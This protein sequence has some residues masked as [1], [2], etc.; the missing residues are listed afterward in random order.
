M[1]EVSTD[2]PS[3]VAPLVMHASGK[4]RGVH[5][6]PW[7]VTG[8][9]CQHPAFVLWFKQPP[10]RHWPSPEV[11]KTRAED[12]ELHSMSPGL[13][14]GAAPGNVGV[15]VWGAKP[16]YPKVVAHITSRLGAPTPA[17]TTSVRVQ[18]YPAQL[19][20]AV[21]EYAL[22][23]R[24]AQK[25]FGPEVPIHVHRCTQLAHSTLDPP[26]FDLE[27]EGTPKNGQCA[28]LGAPDTRLPDRLWERTTR[29]SLWGRYQLVRP[30]TRMSRPEG[31]GE[32]QQQPETTQQAPD[33]TG[34]LAMAN[35]ESAVV[36]VD[37][38]DEDFL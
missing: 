7:I 25:A 13:V 8:A 4:A 24:Y 26:V 30:K 11:W 17:Q 29:S 28:R 34:D 21:D 9:A 37:E 38:E 18:G 23:R 31:S 27:L 20:L 16:A 22:L 33:H 35:A 12:Q 6:R 3:S 19:G 5:F 2:L 10:V 15:R 14:N 32:G 36:D 1:V